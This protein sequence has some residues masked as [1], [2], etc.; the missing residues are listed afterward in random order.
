MKESFKIFS[1][2]NSNDNDENFR[3]TCKKQQNDAEMNTII[4]P[5]IN[6]E[7]DEKNSS[8]QTT[9]NT[10]TMMNVITN[11]IQQQ[12]QNNI[13][14]TQLIIQ[15][16]SSSMKFSVTPLSNDNDDLNK[17]TGF[18]DNNVEQQQQINCRR[19]RSLNSFS[20]VALSS[21]SPTI[22]TTTTKTATITSSSSFSCSLSTELTNNDY[23]NGDNN[24]QMSMTRK[25]LNNND[26]DDEND[27]IQMIKNNDDGDHMVDSDLNVIME[28]TA[29]NSP[30]MNEENNKKSKNIDD[31][32]TSPILNKLSSRL[33]T[34]KMLSSTINLA[35]LN[36]D[37]DT[38]MKSESVSNES[39]DHPTKSA[40]VE[41]IIDNNKN[42]TQNSSVITSTLSSPKINNNNNND[43]LKSNSTSSPYWLG[44]SARALAIL[45]AASPNDSKLCSSEESSPNNSNQNLNSFNIRSTKKM[46]PP[47]L[48]R[49]QSLQSSPSSSS[50][51]SRGSALLKVLQN[52]LKST[53]NTTNL[54][55]KSTDPIFPSCNNNDSIEQQTPTK[56]TP[57]KSILKSPNESSAT[58]K[59]KMVLFTEPVVSNEFYFD[60]SSS[61]LSKSNN[62]IN[63]N[64]KVSSK[65]KKLDLSQG[66]DDNTDNDSIC[67]KSRTDCDEHNVDDHFNIRSIHNQPSSQ[68]NIV[69]TKLNDS[70]GEMII[71]EET[72]T[73]IES[74]S[75]TSNESIELVYSYMKDT[76]SME[77]Y[78]EET[79]INVQNEQHSTTNDES[80]DNSGWIQYV[81]SPTTNSISEDDSKISSLKSNITIEDVSNEHSNNSSDVEVVPKFPQSKNNHH[82]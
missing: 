58:K 42:C 15:P 37:V 17:E 49:T 52:Q 9:T 6:N 72:N 13:R 16:S 70:N 33:N 27:S 48:E 36:F 44:G 54:A 22:T 53:L 3:K 39:N 66:I 38:E 8:Q 74:D 23:N 12:Q 21:S 81:N 18:V 78:P 79:L 82:S 65:R 7:D 34:D 59:K 80:T 63:T 11:N 50:S 20:V 45:K 67:K 68:E 55:P 2:L 10:V 19:R 1:S 69:Q 43:Q 40:I 5:N 73:V 4:I 76:N 71:N 56:S 57:S 62:S 25:I 51:Y 77:K 75:S 41:D 29:H 46:P 35:G 24:D 28:K 14:A 26:D 64:T 47:R 60:I 30:N 61:T 31:L 32:I